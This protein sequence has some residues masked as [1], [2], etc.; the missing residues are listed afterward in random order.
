MAQQLLR[1]K[2]LLS[3]F[4]FRTE[5]SKVGCV[6]LAL[7]LFTILAQAAPAASPFEDVRFH[8]LANGIRIVLD[9]VPQTELAAVAVC[10]RTGSKDEPEDARGVAHLV[11]HLIFKKIGVNG[12]LGARVGSLCMVANAET[13]FDYTAFYCVLRR[14]ML[15][16]AVELLC[17]AIFS[18]KFENS[19]VESEKKV[20]KLELA[21]HSED[22]LDLAKALSQWLLFRSHPYAH[23][24]GDGASNVE[25]LT[26]NKA[27]QFYM[28]N[29]TPQNMTVICSGRF[30]EQTILK[31]IGKTFGAFNSPPA[32]SAFLATQGIN[33]IKEKSVVWGVEMPF[34]AISM[35]FLAPGASEPESFVAGEII[36]NCIGD[37]A[38]GE[39]AKFLK[40]YPKIPVARFRVSFAPRRS[41]SALSISLLLRDKS[42][43]EVESSV[44]DLLNSFKKNGVGNDELVKFKRLAE[45]RFRKRCGD[46]LGRVRVLAEAEGVGTYEIATN[47]INFVGNLGR[48]QI[49]GVARSIFNPNNYAVVA[50]RQKAK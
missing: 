15:Y 3:D 31:A 46:V 30:D 5:W 38:I 6:C 23:P 26:L 10:V 4:G 37:P 12:D 40:K 28:A 20:I 44:L 8:Q 19:L 36:A 2:Q 39:L 35:S 18:P 50:I 14:D 17:S 47:Y 25:H 29:Y 16:R 22:P 13:S 34:N 33:A 48:E 49:L 1:L 21:Q 45:L 43:G 24:F 41:K 42:F 11:E 9:I 32:K 7:A 27:L